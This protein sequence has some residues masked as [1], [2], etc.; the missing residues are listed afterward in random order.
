M[1]HRAAAEGFAK[2][3]GAYVRGRP[4]YPEALDQWLREELGL[5]AS[6][7]V[8]E[9]GAGTGKFTPRL[10]ATGARVIAVE[11]VQ[12]ML[13]QLI[14]SHP[15]VDAHVGTAEQIP[16]GDGMADAV[17]CAQAFH[18]F[19]TPIALREIHR[20]LRPR[21]SLGLVWNVRDESRSW[22][23]ELTAIMDP[24][25]RGTPQ[26]HHGKWRE[27]FPAPG[28]GPLHE[29]RFPHSHVGPPERVIVDRILSVSFIAALEPAQRELVLERLRKL[30]ATHPELAGRKEVAFPYETVAF[31][32]VR[33][34]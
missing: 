20:V 24:Y 27:A 3:A 1:V 15:D 12:Q 16:V 2:E 9:L 18:W 25:E 17:V 14:R 26:Y 6:D 4:D 30:I 28:F 5:R 23:A 19:A 21:G 22:V 31:S 10:L 7:T 29:K 34:D 11:P 33:E 8:V 13:E 32:C